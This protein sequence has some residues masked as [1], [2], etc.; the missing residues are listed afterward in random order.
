M[1]VFF[2]IMM[3]KSCFIFPDLVC[4]NNGAL[5]FT[6]QR[7]FQIGHFDSYKIIVALSLKP[8]KRRGGRRK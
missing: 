8:P 4:V 1:Y 5:N 7:N 3:A 2:E 6:H